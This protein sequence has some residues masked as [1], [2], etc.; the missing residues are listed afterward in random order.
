MLI[1][2]LDIRNAA[3]VIY[4]SLTHQYWAGSESEVTRLC[5]TADLRLCRFNVCPI[6]TQSERWQDWY[7][8]C[9]E[10]L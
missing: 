9:I 10:I 7:G 4:R 8:C 2:L 5:S 6:Q 1:I 3:C